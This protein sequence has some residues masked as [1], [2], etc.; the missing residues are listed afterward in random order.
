MSRKLLFVC[1]LFLICTLTPVGAEEVHVLLNGEAI[2]FQ[3]MQP[4]EIEG[5]VM[6]PVRTVLESLNAQV[7]WDE[8]AQMVTAVRN[9][10]FV[11]LTIGS[12][13]MTLGICPTQGDVAYLETASAMLDVPAQLVEGRTM[14]PLRA[15]A[16]A[17]KVKV[18]WD[19]S[20][21][22]VV[23]EDYRSA[24]ADGWIYYASWS[25]KG[26][27]YKIDTNGQNR[28]KLSDYDCYDIRVIGDYIYY[29]IWSD[30]NKIVYRVDKN[31]Q[32]ERK[33]SDARIYLIS[34]KDNI[35][36]YSNLEESNR[37]ASEFDGKLY[38]MDINCG[39]AERLSSDDISFPVFYDGWIY[40]GNDK[41]NRAIYK[42]DMN[43]KNRTK[44]SPAGMNPYIG[45][46]FLDGWF[47][48]TGDSGD[49][50]YRMDTNGK[51]VTILA[52][53][54]NCNISRIVGNIVYFTIDWDLYRVNTDGTDCRLLA[55][56]DLIFMDDMTDDW[57]YYTDI[58]TEAKKDAIYRVDHNG[59]NKSEVFSGD[60][61]ILKIVDNQLYILDNTGVG[62]D[63]EKGG[64]LYKT[65]MDGSNAKLL[66]E[67][68]M[69]DV[70]IRDQWIYFRNTDDGH[71]YYKMDL[72]GNN[73]QRLTNEQT[74]HVSEVENQ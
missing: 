68:S 54:Q 27:L 49:N 42:I 3:D 41:D 60:A 44:I 29:H 19:E 74:W 18:D 52:K 16:E 48:F 40:Y 14:L 64:K 33:I 25:D 20:T 30:N 4:V 43:G 15:V 5:R 53:G 67:F 32:G 47:Y 21:H 58:G 9:G 56:G 34:V 2:Q 73:L 1:L 23:L 57:I 8:E 46:E 59:Q 66:C 63:D 65:D 12:N 55:E 62:W 10:E 22:S 17:F 70:S 69:R 35:I 24:Q 51:N 39:N 36:Y 26:R 11:R 71:K 45:W 72:D 6:V 28:Q 37:I 31:G 13:R 61:N 38:R 7:S 50:I